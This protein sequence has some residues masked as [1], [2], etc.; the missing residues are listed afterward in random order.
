MHLLF[1]IILS[2]CFEWSNELCWKTA[3]LND[4]SL[5]PVNIVKVTWHRN[6]LLGGLFHQKLDVLNLND[7]SFQP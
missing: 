7:K 2:P 6:P 1:G 3:A 4:P 5:G